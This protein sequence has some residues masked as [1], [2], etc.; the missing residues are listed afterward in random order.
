MQRLVRPDTLSQL[1]EAQKDDFYSDSD[2]N[3]YNTRD[4][5]AV[6]DP[7]TNRAQ[8]CLTCQ[9]G[10]DGVFSTRYGRKRHRKADTTATILLLLLLQRHEAV[11]PRKGLPAHL[12][13]LAKDRVHIISQ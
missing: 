2:K 13:L 10:R 8:R 3:A 6:S 11:T 12:G 4:S 5:Q 9:I 7:S 1:S